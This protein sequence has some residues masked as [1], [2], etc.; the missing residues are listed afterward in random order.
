MR[1]HDLESALH[2]LGVVQHLFAEHGGGLPE[3]R[4]L[5]AIE[6][7]SGSIARL[8][9]DC[10]CQQK[11]LGLRISAQALYSER[12]HLSWSRPP[13]SGIDYLRLRILKDLNELEGRIRRLYKIR[14]ASIAENTLAP[15]DERRARPALRAVKKA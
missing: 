6:L 3:P 7:L 9:S 15:H 11:L 8:L 5:G 4:L 14:I 12:D 10:L 13:L 1:H 2:H